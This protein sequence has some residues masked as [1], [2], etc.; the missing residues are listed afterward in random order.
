MQGRQEALWQQNVA[1]SDIDTLIQTLLSSGYG[2]I[3][4][5]SAVYAQQTSQEAAVNLCNTLTE[6]LQTAPIISENGELYFWKIK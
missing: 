2:G 5:D 3:Y 6:K 1:G 4:L